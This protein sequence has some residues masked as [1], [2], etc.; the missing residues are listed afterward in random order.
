MDDFI[1]HSYE[2]LFVPDTVVSSKLGCRYINYFCRWWLGGGGGVRHN[3]REIWKGV[4]ANLPLL[5][6]GIV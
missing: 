5:R 4:R 2:V 6:G 1:E 3:F